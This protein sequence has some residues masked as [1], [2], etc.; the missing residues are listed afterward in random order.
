MTLE[1]REQAIEAAANAIKRDFGLFGN[2]HDRPIEL[3]DSSY[4]DVAAAA[5]DAVL[6]LVEQAQLAESTHREEIAAREAA[7]REWP[8]R[9]PGP[10]SWSEIRSLLSE[11]ERVERERD[12]CEKAK[13]GYQAINDWRELYEKAAGE[14]EQ[15][16]CRNTQLTE[17]LRDLAAYEQVGWRSTNPGA[18]SWRV[19]APPQDEIDSGLWEPVYRQRQP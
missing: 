10:P 7:S 6:P 1:Q 18:P 19:S 4:R 17:A 12:E 11:L 9:T 14:R 15:L 2:L 8:K 16:E 5:L 13:A 3:S